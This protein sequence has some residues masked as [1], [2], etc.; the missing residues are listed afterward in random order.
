MILPGISGSLLLI[1]LSQYTRMTDALKEF[2]DGLLGFVTGG[3]TEGFAVHAQ[4]VVV[5]VLGGLVG[6]FT[7]ARLVKGALARNREATYAFLVALV[8]GALRAPVA[9]LNGPD[10]DVAW[11]TDT[12]GL[13]AGVAVAG[14]LVV[15]VLDW[16]AVDIDLDAA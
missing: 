6:L 11:T 10:Y 12:I 5:F 7:V 1:I 3:S 15:L 9:T 4:E 8:V 14:G 13:F 16:Y 2:L